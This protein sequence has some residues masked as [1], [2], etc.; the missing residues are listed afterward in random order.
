MFEGYSWFEVSNRDPRVVHLYARHYSSKKNGKSIK[1]WLA[2][3]ISAN[4][5]DVTM[6][7]SDSKALWGWLEQQIRHDH[8]EGI[9]CYVFRNESNILSSVLIN[10]AVAIAQEYWPSQRLWTYV[11]PYKIDSPNPGYCFKVAG[12]K[13]KGQSKGGLHILELS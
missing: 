10:D 2:H 12:W 5:H 4:G 6:L 1:D 7:T 3:G 11:N 8:Q 9:Q 13:H